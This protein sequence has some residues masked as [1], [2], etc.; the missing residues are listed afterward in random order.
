[1]V[2][3]YHRLGLRTEGSDTQKVLHLGLAHS[4]HARKAGCHS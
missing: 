1:M 4:K 3:T 2:P